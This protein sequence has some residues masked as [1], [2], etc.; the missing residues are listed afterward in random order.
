MYS[1]T[2][3][4]LVDQISANQSARLIPNWVSAKSMHS[5]SANNGQ[6]TAPHVS[7]PSSGNRQDHL[8]GS[9]R[10]NVAFRFING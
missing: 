1:T 8:I 5:S 4:K 3:C 2:M 6:T 10:I 9:L 7:G